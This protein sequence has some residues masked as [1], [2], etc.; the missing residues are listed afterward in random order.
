MSD[1]PTQRLDPR[2]VYCA[3]DFKKIVDFGS[4]SKRDGHY[5]WD[6]R[7]CGGNSLKCAHPRLSVPFSLGTHAERMGCR[8]AFERGEPSGGDG[9]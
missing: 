3:T 4:G 9:A 7:H 8:G 5:C 2:F 1:F 6:C